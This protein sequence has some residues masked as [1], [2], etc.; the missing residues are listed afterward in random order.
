LALRNPF[1]AEEVQGHLLVFKE[2]GA[3]L[4]S[5]SLP[6]ETGEIQWLALPS[7]SLLL[8][9]DGEKITAHQLPSGDKLYEIVGVQYQPTVS[10]GGKYVAALTEQGIAWHST[11]DGQAAGLLPL[12]P[13]WLEKDPARVSGNDQV[14]KRRAMTNF[15]PGGKSAAIV[16]INPHSDLHFANV[17]LATGKI[18]EAFLLPHSR[19]QSSPEL[20]GVWTSERQLLLSDG[21]VVDFDLKTFLARYELG[22]W[23]GQS[24]DGR[25]W[26]AQRLKYDQVEAVIGKLGETKRAED[27]RRNEVVLAATTLPDESVT[28]Q[29]AEAR[30]GFIWRADMETRLEISGHLPSEEREKTVEAFAA[31]V[32]KRGVRINPQAKYA[33]RLNIGVDDGLVVGKTEAAYDP[34]YRKEY[35]EQGKVG[36]MRVSV[37][38]EQGEPMLLSGGGAQVNRTYEQG[39]ED[40]VWRELRERLTGIDLPRVYF[41]D[42][43]GKR[44]PIS[45][46]S[47]KIPIGIDGVMEASKPNSPPGDTYGLPKDLGY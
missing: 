7:D 6:A 13:K 39:G 11:A 33:L 43:A 14:A 27:V 20:A 45:L 32:T 42:A 21:M 25:Y 3:K 37:V 16:A 41:R 31:A 17:E 19:T 2:E 46:S 26:R 9:Y 5:I 12:P 29:L 23:P 28:T 38:D 1:R 30:Q 10:P 18:K 8:A 35:Y 15:H 47:G 24:P 34:N 40:R 44:L 4:A 22:F 36:K